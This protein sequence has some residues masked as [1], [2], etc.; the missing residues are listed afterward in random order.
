M[1][2]GAAF[3]DFIHEL[4]EAVET[5]DDAWIELNMFGIE[6]VSYIIKHYPDLWRRL[7]PEHDHLSWK[8]TSRSSELMINYYPSSLTG[9]REFIVNT[10]GEVIF[11]KVMA[12]GKIPDRDIAGSLL[13]QTARAIASQ[14]PESAGFEFY[15]REFLYEQHNLEV[16]KWDLQIADR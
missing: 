14:I 8:L 7:Q 10:N 4:E 16:V 11:P 12:K 6:Y 3:T 5:L 1:V 15:Y 9:I 2:T 13:E